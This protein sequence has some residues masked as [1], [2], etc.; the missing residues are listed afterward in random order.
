M[1]GG[2]ALR[3]RG[4]GVR[5]PARERGGKTRGAAAWRIAC[6]LLALAWPASAQRYQT[7]SYTEEDGLPSASILGIDQDGLGRLWISARNGVAVYDGLEWTGYGS[8][9]GLSI[10]SPGDIEIDDRGRVW[11]ASRGFS[12]QV[13]FFDGASWQSLPLLGGP[14]DRG[15]I[16]DLKVWEEAGEDRVAV[17]L[18]LQGVSIWRDGR[19]RLLPVDPSLADARFRNLERLDGRLYLASSKGFCLVDDDGIRPFPWSNPEAA[20]VDILA[21]STA[22]D[23]IAGKDQAVWLWGD[24]RLGIL[25]NGRFE[26][27]AER[28]G[29]PGDPIADSLNFVL[30]VDKRG[31]VFYGDKGTLLALDLESGMQRRLGMNHGLIGE[32]A[33]ALFQDREENLWIGCDRGLAKIPSFRFANY[34]KHEGLLE[35]EVS[36]LFETPD[37]TMIMGHNNGLTLLQNGRLTTRPFFEAD[38][39]DFFETRVMCILGDSRGVVW[40]AGSHLGLGRLASDGAIEWFGAQAGL[41]GLATALAFDDEGALWVGGNGGLS[42]FDNGRFYPMNPE[43]VSVDIRFLAW[44]GDRLLAATVKNGLAILENG[45]WRFAKHAGDPLANNLYTVAVDHNGRTWVGSAIGLLEWRDGQLEKIALGE[46][47]DRRAV[48]LL[49]QDDQR[50]LWLGTDHGVARWDGHRVDSYLKAHGLV[51]LE[52]NRGAGLADRSGRVWIGTVS[53]AS[54]YDE[55]HDRPV[56]AKPILTVERLHAGAKDLSLSRDLSLGWRDNTLF[57]KLHCL[58]LID[59]ERVAYRAWLEGFD[60]GWLDPRPYDDPW[61]RYPNLAAGDYRLH[62]RARNAL[63]VWSDDIVSSWVHIPKP[64]WLQSWFLIVCGA[65]LLGVVY[66]AHRQWVTRRMSA[67]LRS[68]VQIKTLELVDKTRELELK[69]RQ[70]QQELGKRAKIERALTK[71]KERAEAGSRA[72]SEFLATMSH[73]IRTPLNGVIATA[74]LLQD[75]TLDGEQ[76]EYADIIKLSGEALQSVINDILDFSR[77][78]SGRLELDRERFSPRKLVA[79]TA[80]ILKSKAEE[81]RV[82]IRFDI[83]PATPEQV[84]GDAARIRQVLLNLLGNAVKFTADGEAAVTVAPSAESSDRLDIAVADTGVGIPADKLDALF[85]PFTQADSSTS[86]KFGGAGLGLA[87]S[88]RLVELMGGRIW[89]RSQPGRGSV[90]AFSIPLEASGPAPAAEPDNLAKASPAAAFADLRVLVVEDNAVNRKILV[91]LLQRLS[92]GRVDVAVNGREA[93]AR[94]TAQS[95]DLILMDLQM[96]EMDGLEATRRITALAGAQG[97]PS[98]I[99]CTANATDDE[100]RRCLEAGIVDFIPKPVALETIRDALARWGPNV[101]GAA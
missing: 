25:R 4:F 73:E 9:E 71:A 88:K 99:A 32:G 70:L 28:A 90:F 101:I 72:K 44:H 80:A 81:N 49:F 51:G 82:A 48:F 57:F 54:V 84:W 93:L 30:L 14:P 95:Y 43:G 64:F 96:P 10:S 21:T 13:S 38:R 26:T 3:I 37:G 19:W 34:T 2:N 83:D 69:N 41:R 24:R 27:V 75:T 58:S 85:Q 66:L 39:T 62:V 11:V 76:R 79:Q 50:R 7:R 23:P 33:T 65:S 97:G 29:E 74:S 1:T 40:L 86:R 17:S 31:Q 22:P 100:R 68:Q 45:H 89:A 46:E 56:R 53:G 87:I 6:C 59:E 98:V 47:I 15:S 94:A 92:V 16:V 60:T 36:A 35:D 18:A 67:L 55:T 61:L 63:G 78:E 5:M 77:I 91:K 8:A 52:A 20:P 42:R 12:R